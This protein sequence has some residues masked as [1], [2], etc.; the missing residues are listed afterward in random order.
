MAHPPRRPRR[1]TLR[2]RGYDYSSQGAYFVTLCTHQRACL[3]GKILDG[4]TQLS[5]SGRIAEDFWQQIPTHFPNVELDEFIVMPNHLHGIIVIKQ[6]VIDNRPGTSTHQKFGNMLKPGALST[7]VRSFKSATT[8]HINLLRAAP[9]S[10]VWQRNY[11]DHIIRNAASYGRIQ[12][13]I[14][15]NPLSWQTDQLHPDTPSKE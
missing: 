7:I 15:Q 9:G 4:K 5:P 2:L 12:Y 13:Y 6:A 11:Y 3:F 1:N 10:P 8:R 14:R